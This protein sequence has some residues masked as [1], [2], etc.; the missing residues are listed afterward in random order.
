MLPLYREEALRHAA[1]RLDGKVLLP[2]PLSTWLIGGVLVAA[3]VLAASFAATASYARSETV[4]GWLAPESGVVRVTALS[5]GVVAELLAS[6]GDRVAPDAPLAS[7]RP[8]A[9]G[10]WGEGPARPDALEYIVTAPIGGRVDALVVRPGQSLTAGSPVAVL[11]PSGDE[12]VAELFVP[13]RAA[14]FINAGQTLKLKYEAF[15]YQRFGSQEA[16]VDKVSLTVLAPEETGIPGMAFSEPVFSARGRLAAQTVQAYGASVPLRAG[17][18]LSADVVIDRRTL[19][20]W[21]LDPLYA[22]GRR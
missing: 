4:R 18:L 10:A 12:L 19:A 15:P 9:V 11:V 8:L 13:S 5:G 7:I 22:V 16:T 2:S 3:L 1:G 6:E 14:G 21:L 20:E 17:M